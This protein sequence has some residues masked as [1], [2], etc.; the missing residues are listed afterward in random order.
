MRDFLPHPVQG[1]L[2]YISDG[3]D[4]VGE[5]MFASEYLAFDTLLPGIQ[6]MLERLGAV[7]L[8]ASLQQRNA[9]HMLRLKAGAEDRL[10]FEVTHLVLR[11]YSETGRKYPYIRRPYAIFFELIKAEEGELLL[12]FL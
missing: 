7:H 9:G 1:C 11:N 8:D 2:L 12:F 5:L 10:T 4:V 3:P 6:K